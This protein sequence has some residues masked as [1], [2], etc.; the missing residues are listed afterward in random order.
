MFCATCY[1]IKIDS[2][3]VSVH[4]FSRGYNSTTW[5]D[6]RLAV[7]GRDSC[8][9]PRDNCRASKDNYRKYYG[10]AKKKKDE[11]FPHKYC[12]DSYARLFDA[13]DSPTPT[14][15]TTMPSALAA[16]A[17]FLVARLLLLRPSV[18]T[19]MNDALA[20]L[21][22]SSLRPSLIPTAVF[23]PLLDWTSAAEN[24]INSWAEENVPDETNLDEYCT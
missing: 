17:A 19:I 22:P 14:A 1:T 24:T 21:L 2:R 6:P 3:L 11:K 20:G 5:S 7:C 18:I 8:F 23:V 10:P 13:A 15:N 12:I 16:F 9:C 4:T